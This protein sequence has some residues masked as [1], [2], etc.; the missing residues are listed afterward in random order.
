[1]DA[2]FGVPM[3]TP[4]DLVQFME[5]MPPSRIVLAPKSY[6][7]FVKKDTRNPYNLSC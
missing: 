4:K 2:S 5:G 7:I 6:M 1:M 3:K